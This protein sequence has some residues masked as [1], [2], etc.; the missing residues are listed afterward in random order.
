MYVVAL[1]SQIINGYFLHVDGYVQLE[2]KRVYIEVEKKHAW[3]FQKWA[4]NIT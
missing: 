2:Y 1:I 3:N 4:R